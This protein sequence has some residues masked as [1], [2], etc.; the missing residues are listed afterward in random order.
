MSQMSM[1]ALID[2]IGSLLYFSIDLIILNR[3]LGP[4]SAGKYAP[5]TMLVMLMGRIT[6]AISMIFSPVAYELIAKKEI[7]NLTKIIK[8]TIKFLSIFIAFPVAILCGFSE[9]ILF[10]WVGDPISKLHPILWILLIPCIFGYS[11]RPI[12]AINRGFNKIMFPSIITL[13]G[14][15]A[16]LILSIYFVS[17]TSLGIYG[18]AI[19][20][21]IC[22]NVRDF[23]FLPIYTAK[24]LNQ[25]W[26]AI[27]SIPIPGIILFTFM[28]ITT[29]TIKKVFII[30]SLLFLTIVSAIIVLFFVVPIFFILTKED[31]KFIKVL[32]LKNN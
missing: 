19:S 3:L 15:I 27:Y 18:V 20:T 11:I 21:V 12:F 6:D 25:K 31:K 17:K 14:G 2:N 22:L 16:N 1:W 26:F 5:L 7:E 23:I 30:D 8:R 28:F 4:E 29:L 32:I 10:F 24:L 13:I 9:E